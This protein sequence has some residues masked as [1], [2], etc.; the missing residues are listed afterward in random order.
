MAAWNWSAAPTT[1]P[2]PTSRAS[3]R[4]SATRCTAIGFQQRVIGGVPQTAWQLDVFG[5]DPQ[6]PQVMSGAGLTSTAFA[7]GPYHQWGPMLTSWNIREHRK[8]FAP[9]QFPTEFEWVAPSGDGLLT[10]YMAGHYAAGFSLDTAQTAQAAASELH[11]LFTELQQAAATR[12]VMIPMGSDFTPPM[13]WITELRTAWTEQC[14]HVR[15][16]CALPRDFFAAV[17]AELAARGVRPTPQTRDMNPIYTGK[18]VNAIDT[19]QAH[20]AVETLLLDAE[21]WATFAALNGAVYPAAA[22]DKAW[23]L[24][25]F[26]AHHDAVTGTHSDQVYLDLLAG[27]REAHDLA[28]TVDNS[29]RGH[30]AEHIDT[31]GEGTPIVVF[32]PLA[33]PRTDTVSLHIDLDHTDGVTLTDEGGIP[34][35]YLAEALTHTSDGQTSTALLRWVARDVPSMGYR[36]YRLLPGT[37]PASASAW[38]PTETTSIANDRYRLRADPAQGGALTEITDLVCGRDILPPGQ[39]ANELICIAEYPE[40]PEFG[41]GPWHLLPAGVVWRSAHAAATVTVERCPIGERITAT[42][43]VEGCRYT[44]HTTVWYGVER[45]DFTTRIDAFTET[46]RLLRVRVPCHV[47]GSMPISETAAAVIGR[48]YALLDA[49]AA[50]HPWTLDNAC[51]RWFGLGAALTVHFD[52]PQ[53][54][55]ERSRAVSI[56]EIVVPDGDQGQRW[57][58]QLAVGLVRAGVTATVTTATGNRYGALHTDSN[59]PDFRVAVG[60]PERNTFVADLLDRAPSGFTAE[61]SAQLAATGT[62]RLWI[63]EAQPTRGVWR[64]GA[65][66]RGIRDLPV[67]LVAGTEKQAE[68]RAITELINDLSDAHLHVTQPHTLHDHETTGDDYAV[69][70]INRGTP[71][72]AVEPDGTLNI[73][74]ARASTG[75]PTGTAIN[76]PDLNAPGGRSF[77]HH[78]SRRFEYS[79][80]SGIGGWRAAGFTAAGQSVNHPLAA[81]IAPATDGPLPA[82][83]SFLS[84]EPAGSLV[85]TAVKPQGDPLAAGC[86]GPLDPSEGLIVRGY[87]PHG[88]TRRVAI[89]LAGGIAS[90][91]A[92]DLLDRPG[93]NLRHDGQRAHVDVQGYKITSLALR[94]ARAEP[95]QALLAS[96]TEPVQPVFTRYWLHNRGPAP[97]GNLP[98]TLTLRPDDGPPTDN[99]TASLRLRAQIVCDGADTDYTTHL[100]VRPPDGWNATPSSRRLTIPAGGHRTV[101]ITVAIPD[102]ATPGWYAV[103]AAID[104]Q[105]QDLQDVLIVPVGEAPPVPLLHARS[106]CRQLTLAPGARGRLGVAVAHTLQTPLHGHIQLITPHDIWPLT[107]SPIRGFTVLPSST[108]RVE[109]AVTVP[110]T[111]PPGEFWAQPKICAYGHVTYSEPVRIHIRA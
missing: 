14:P 28:A 54:R 55:S 99:A 42:G 78:T 60:T 62:A 86:A 27:W 94:P 107:S 82:A 93:E 70:L 57:T 76:F 68:Q 106:E 19:K 8:P 84:L 11:G 17:R 87:E 67:L 104:H 5:H 102:T 44:Q 111:T 40:H 110:A 65:D 56:A 59:V 15:L 85:V 73:S 3:R 108:T 7:R 96:D 1:N 51:H 25:L 16:R 63:Q 20:R 71:S 98:V 88:H 89:R 24:L 13:R 22:L 12:N 4:L 100:R 38:Q 81:R 10:H 58:R 53:D 80:V 47:P 95:G 46:D 36:T 41:E 97:M 30:L 18:D 92:V 23:R 43:V 79:L 75:W 21:K 31:R 109:F 2:T 32:N 69:A 29:A 26:A 83:G 9:I 105:G 45:I 52:D 64:P 6:F 103:A 72:F 101:P 35:P 90:A 37:T 74:L 39:V 33:H 49:D 66:V 77:Q 50:E 34:I 91:A 61:L 48:G